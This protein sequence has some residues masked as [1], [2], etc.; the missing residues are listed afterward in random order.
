MENPEICKELHEALAG[1]IAGKIY[2]KFMSKFAQA[3][4]FA[5]DIIVLE[6]AE[7]S[8]QLLSQK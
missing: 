5:S 8:Q 6:Q 2:V 4:T 7:L 1:S 3:T